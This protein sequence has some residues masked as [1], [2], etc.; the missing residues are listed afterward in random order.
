[1]QAGCGARGMRGSYR[2]GAAFSGSEVPLIRQRLRRCHLPP[3]GRLRACA[4]LH[5]CQEYVS[6]SGA[7]GSRVAQT[8]PGFSPKQRAVYLLLE[9]ESASRFPSKT[10]LWGSGAAAFRK[11]AG[12]AF[13]A[14]AGRLCRPGHPFLKAKR[15]VPQIC[16]R[17]M[18]NQSIIKRPHAPQNIPMLSKIRL[19]SLAR[20][21]QAAAWP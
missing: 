2:F 3:R 12:G 4:K 17:L 21:L 19:T 9:R 11:C 6:G 13:L 5:I 15:N 8:L 14:E 7:G 16:A 18:C 20:S 10:F 1:M